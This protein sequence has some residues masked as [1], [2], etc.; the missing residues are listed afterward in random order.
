MFHLQCRGEQADLPK[1]EVQ[2]E[3]SDMMM[4]WLAQ[5]S[6]ILQRASTVKWQRKGH[7]V[8]GS[9]LFREFSK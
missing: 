5:H 3:A 4:V 2:N 6:C 8:S 7:D 9:D 1:N